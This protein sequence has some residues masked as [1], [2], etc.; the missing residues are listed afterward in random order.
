VNRALRAVTLGVLLF[1]PVALTACS[2]GQETQTETQNRD[3]TGPMAEVGD[4]ALRQIQ[5]AYPSG[6]AYEDGD[7]AELQMTIVNT[8]TED[9]TLT[10]ITGDGFSDF[11]ITGG[12]TAAGSGGSTGSRPEVQI[13]ADSSLQLGEE[14]P[15][16]TLENLSDTLT[17][18][19][20]IELTLEFENAGE[21][22]V[23]A[24]VATSDRALPRGD[25]YDFH[26]EGGEGA[27]ELGGAEGSAG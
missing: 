7:D 18:G 9:D 6:G 8:G 13:P 5:L 2:A 26:D 23:Q 21:V 16:V 25:A 20:S 19:Q 17:P 1:S 3:K 24:Q 11:R 22:T 12:G 4:L 27:E 10:D 15:T 14:G